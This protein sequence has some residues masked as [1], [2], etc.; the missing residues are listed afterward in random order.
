MPA[1]MA[2]IVGPDSSRAA[3]YA[4][5]LRCPATI[6]SSW[7][8]VPAPE[9]NRCHSDSVWRRT[10]TLYPP[11]LRVAWLSTGSLH[12]ASAVGSVEGT[13]M[14]GWL[15]EAL[16]ESMMRFSQATTLDPIFLQSKL[17]SSN[18]T[19]ASGDL[20]VIWHAHVHCV[21]HAMI[22]YQSP[23]TLGQRAPLEKTGNSRKR[24]RSTHS[25][26]ELETKSRMVADLV[27]MGETK[28]DVRPGSC[29][30]RFGR[31][32]ID[33]TPSSIPLH[34]SQIARPV[35]LIRPPSWISSVRREPNRLVDTETLRSL[36][37]RVWMVRLSQS[38][39]RREQI[40]RRCPIQE[41]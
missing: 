34:V 11:Y 16:T 4:A 22:N 31:S 27:I 28:F 21:Q 15:A 7:H 38:E 17:R 39:T 6:P 5:R 30:F 24:G 2:W 10:G 20:L 23:Q 37:S 40:H 25:A 9:L 35:R 14:A 18:A 29:G 26:Y 36:R 32:E 33:V 8:A 19:V 3:R 41:I 12:H 13:E 1:A